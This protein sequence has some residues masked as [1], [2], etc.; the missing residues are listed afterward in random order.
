MCWNVPSRDIVN[1]NV[2][3]KLSDLSQNNAHS[4]VCAQLGGPVFVDVSS[5]QISGFTRFIGKS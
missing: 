1:K 5:G 2:V 4:R 3:L